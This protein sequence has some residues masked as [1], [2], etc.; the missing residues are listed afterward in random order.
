MGIHC[1]AP[2]RSGT[3]GIRTQPV[4]FNTA[5]A[6][7]SRSREGATRKGGSFFDLVRSGLLL[8]EAEDSLGDL[9]GLGEHRR[10][11]LAEDLVLGEGDHLGRHVHVTHPGL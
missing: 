5:K 7:S 10:A 6:E 11:G 8:Q 4:P 3:I 1:P 9:V 2:D